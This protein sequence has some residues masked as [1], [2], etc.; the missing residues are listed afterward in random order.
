MDLQCIL[1]AMIVYA[2]TWICFVLVRNHD[3]NHMDMNH[4][5]DVLQTKMG[6]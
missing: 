3:E 1:V 4:G 2:S 5:V 6:C